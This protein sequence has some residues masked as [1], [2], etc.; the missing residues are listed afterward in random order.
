MAVNVFYFV[1]SVR[2]DGYCW[3]AEPPESRSEH[4][5]VLTAGG[6]A[7]ARLRTYNPFEETPALFRIFAQI[8]PADRDAILA[9][10]NQ[11]GVLGMFRDEYII[12]SRQSSSGEVEHGLQVREMAMPIYGE[13]LELWMWEIFKM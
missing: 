2:A 7:S 4:P 6:S 9:F 12:R 11:Y 13:P 8:P 1:W 3:K 10:A 5:W